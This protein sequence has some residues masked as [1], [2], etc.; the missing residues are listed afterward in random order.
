MW[1][2]FFKWTSDLD[3][4]I[5]EIFNPLLIYREKKNSKRKLSELRLYVQAPAMINVTSQSTLKSFFDVLTSAA[6]LSLV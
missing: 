6:N 5:H 4:I 1:Y 3:C 2:E